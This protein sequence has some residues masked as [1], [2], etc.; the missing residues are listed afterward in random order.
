MGTFLLSVPGDT[1]NERQQEETGTS[2]PAARC[3]GE[4]FRPRRN[5]SLIVRRQEPSDRGR[6]NSP[7][8]EDFRRLTA[9]LAPFQTM[10]EVSWPKVGR[11]TLISQFRHAS[12]AECPLCDRPHCALLFFRR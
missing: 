1:S 8:R 11:I 9:I 2:E 10:L 5:F 4:G 3:K 12:T 7:P 6:L